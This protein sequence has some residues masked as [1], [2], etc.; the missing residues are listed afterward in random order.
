MQSNA[1]RSKTLSLLAGPAFQSNGTSV[2]PCSQYRTAYAKELNK[3]LY[4]DDLKKKKSWIRCTTAELHILMLKKIGHCISNAAYLHFFIP[5]LCKD[6][7][8][9]THRSSIGS[10]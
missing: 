3:N 9:S 7:E 10:Q 5:E 4:S 8:C 2:S 1:V 6:E